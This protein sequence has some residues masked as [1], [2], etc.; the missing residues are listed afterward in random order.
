MKKIILFI[1]ITLLSTGPFCPTTYC[2]EKQAPAVQQNAEKN[3]A[4]PTGKNPEVQNVKPKKPVEIKLH[5]NA[6]GEY[7]WDIAGDSADGICRADSRLKKIPQARKI[8]PA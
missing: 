8:G 4:F 6:N 5:R 1:L 7:T 2:A 3:T